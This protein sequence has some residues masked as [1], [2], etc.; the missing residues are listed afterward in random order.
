MP[1]I[2]RSGIWCLRCEYVEDAEDLHDGSC[3]SCGCPG[4]GHV[5]CKVVTADY[6]AELPHPYGGITLA[7]IAA[8][9]ERIRREFG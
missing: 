2:L 6:N 3:V 8:E 1:E 9:A 5:P 7:G 4:D